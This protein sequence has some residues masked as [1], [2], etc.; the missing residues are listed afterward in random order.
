[1]PLERL[2]T[3]QFRNLDN[4]NLTFNSGLN[5]IFGMNASGKTSLLEAAHVLCSGKSFLR[6]SPQKLQQFNSI[7]FS[8]NGI[9]N[10]H[11]QPHRYQ[12]L[13]KDHSVHLK[14]NEQ[15]VR[16]IS[17][18]AL[19]QPVQAITPASFKL[20]DESPEIRRRFIDWGVFHVKHQYIDAWHRYQRSLSQRNAM[21]S[22][23]K[24]KSLM[25]WDIEYAKSCEIIDRYRSEYIAALQS[26][27]ANI[28][29]RLLPDTL[30]T[31][32]YHRGWGKDSHLNDLLTQSQSRDIERGYT[33]YGPQRAE[34]NIVLN[35]HPAKDTASRG[36]KKLITY[37]LYIA[38]AEIQQEQG[39][40]SG[41]LLVDDLPSELDEEHRSLVLD[42]LTDLPMQVILSCIDPTDIEQVV[43]HSTKLFH[44][45]QGKVEV[46][47]Q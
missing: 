21:L 7:D 47:L 24:G 15:I 10:H 44:V 35:G 40:Y 3:Y 28:V 18:Y 45:K 1:M 14:I 31:I 27:F 11:E 2:K 5:V 41:L 36:Q 39:E 13:W 19:Q 43:K 9:M 38:Q 22:Q 29:K 33:Y 42:L 6:A 46:V 32:G 20:I 12:Y 37:A 4:I 8:L 25:P 34:L 30:V 23:A 26:T 16:K 17:R